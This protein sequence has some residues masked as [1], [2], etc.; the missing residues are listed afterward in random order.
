M[1]LSD[2]GGNTVTTM[3]DYAKQASAQLGWSDGLIYAQWVLETGNFTSSVFEK[4]NNLAGIKWVS[5]KNNPGSSP[6]STANDGGVYAHFPNLSAGVQGYVNFIKSNPRYAN[7]KTG[8]TLAEQAQ[9]L[10]NDGWATDKNYVSKV[11]SIAGGNSNVNVNDIG[12]STQA[13]TD[14]TTTSV[15]EKAKMIVTSPIFWVVLL[16][17]LVFK[18]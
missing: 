15:Q 3:R 4:D 9:I 2:G 12:S 8:R 11:V 6:G 14:N 18:G 16:A 13:T 1:N 10:K 5:A 7:V 17:G